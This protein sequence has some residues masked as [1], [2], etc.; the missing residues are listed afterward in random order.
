MFKELNV[1]A[2]SILNRFNLGI[3]I[4]Q[5]IKAIA[6]KVVSKLLDISAELKPPDN[7]NVRA[8]AFSAFVRI[9]KA[10]IELAKILTDNPMRISLEIE[11]FENPLK[12]ITKTDVNNAPINP[13]NE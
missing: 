11:N 3:S 10:I 6:N 1:K 5:I 2:E 13:N 12:Q 8:Y 9:K 4:I 7:I